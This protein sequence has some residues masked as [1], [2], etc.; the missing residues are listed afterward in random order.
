MPFR[1][2]VVLLG[3]IGAALAAVAYPFVGLLAMLFLN[4]G[5]P[6][7]DRPNIIALHLPMMIT[8]AVLIGTALR[9]GSTIK[10]MLSGLKQLK[11]VFLL[12]ALFVVSALNNW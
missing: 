4:F 6:Q 10:P 3:G 7:D 11:V 8:V 5:R 12:L 1:I 2:L 9:L